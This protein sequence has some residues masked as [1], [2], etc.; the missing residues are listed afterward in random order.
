MVF[1]G[2]SIQEPVVIF[3]EDK[4]IIFLACVG[5]RLPGERMSITE[6]VSSC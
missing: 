1:V 3:P 4:A 5:K 2:F 6:L